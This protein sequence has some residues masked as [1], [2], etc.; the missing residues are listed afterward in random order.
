MKLTVIGCLGGFPAEGKATS[1]FLLESKGFNLLIDCGSGALLALQKVLSPLQLDAALLTHFHADHIADVG[2]LQHFWQLAPGVK[3]VPILP[4]YASDHDLENFNKLDWPE[5]TQKQALDFTKPMQI[6]PFTISFFKT[7]HPVE[8]YAVRIKEQGN[9]NEL[10]YTADTTMVSGLGDFIKGA[11]VLLADTN[12]LADKPEPRWH[13]TTLETAQL[14]NQ[15]H[16]QHVILTHLPPFGDANAFKREVVA[17]LVN[18][19]DVEIAREG[20]ICE[21]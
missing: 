21:I 3:K 4:I 9:S 20:L 11:K 15:A 19:T 8:T 5:S 13:L 10:V 2:V 14:A 6:G 12:F 16:V 1:C 7:K 18:E 17:G